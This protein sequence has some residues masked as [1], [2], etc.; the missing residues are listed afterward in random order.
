MQVNAFLV[1]LITP[2]GIQ[3]EVDVPEDTTV[4]E[5]AEDAGIE[6]DY[7]CQSGSCSSCMGKLKK[8]AVDQEDQSILDDDQVSRGWTCLCV[9]YPLEDC[10]IETNKQEEFMAE[11]AS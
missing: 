7:S 5:A 4:L 11:Q 6:L 8:G 10:V 2:D 3:H 9:A 1:T